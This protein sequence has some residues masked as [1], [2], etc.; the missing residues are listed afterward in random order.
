MR[1]P[2]FPRVLQFS[3]TCLR[4]IRAIWGNYNSFPLVFLTPRLGI[5]IIE[6]RCF[7]N[8]PSYR[9]VLSF[10]H[11]SPRYFVVLSSCSSFLFWPIPMALGHR[12]E[13]A[14]Y[15]TDPII[16]NI[17]EL[18]RLNL[19]NGLKLTVDIVL[20]TVSLNLRI[21]II[22]FFFNFI[23]HFDCKVY[24]SQNNLSSHLWINNSE[25][26]RVSLL[27]IVTFAY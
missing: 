13:V 15:C 14:F 20:F 6:I 12:Y 27:F 7:A 16:K 25:I 5:R 11:G 3:R 10:P 24:I 8:F 18:I 17:R 9:R 21:S 19:D 4:V 2:F 1:L 22:I 23:L 26:M